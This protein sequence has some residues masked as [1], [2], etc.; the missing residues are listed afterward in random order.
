VGGG[1]E[2]TPLCVR[3]R[4]RTPVFCA[5]VAIVFFF[6]LKESRL[7]Q[8]RSVYGERLHPT[9]RGGGIGELLG[10]WFLEKEEEEGNCKRWVEGALSRRER[11]RGFGVRGRRAATH[12]QRA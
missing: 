6:F 8:L 12:T 9:K 4:A 2:E 11:E 5:R 7:G 10:A 3:A 1:A